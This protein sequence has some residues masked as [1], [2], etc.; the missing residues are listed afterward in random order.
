M[1]HFQCQNGKLWKTDHPGFISDRSGTKTWYLHFLMEG[2]SI[3]LLFMPFHTETNMLHLF[4]SQFIHLENGNNIIMNL[5]QRISHREM[6]IISSK[7]YF[8]PLYILEDYIPLIIK[9]RNSERTHYP[10]VFSYVRPE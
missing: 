10:G 1:Q 6:I 7:Y 9:P 4:G 2:S 3:I 8:P 5:V